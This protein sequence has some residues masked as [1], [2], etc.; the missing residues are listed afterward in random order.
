MRNDSL[1][2]SRIAY[3]VYASCVKRRVNGADGRNEPSGFVPPGN[4]PRPCCAAGAILA[5]IATA[6]HATTC[7]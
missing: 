2:G 5:A 7:L 1:P 3:S 4:C 6:T